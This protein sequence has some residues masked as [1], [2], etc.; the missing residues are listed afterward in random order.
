MEFAHLNATLRSAHSRRSTRGRGRHGSPRRRSLLV[1]DCIKLDRN[2][3]QRSPSTWPEPTTM[4]LAASGAYTWRR[5]IGSTSCPARRPE[6]RD[7]P[8]WRDPAGADRQ[9]RHLRCG[10][11]H[12]RTYYFLLE[13][14]HLD[15][16][17]EPGDQVTPSRRVPDF[18]GL[19]ADLHAHGI[20]VPL[21]PSTVVLSPFSRPCRSAQDLDGENHHHDADAAGG[22][23][24]RR[25]GGL[26][27]A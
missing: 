9:P 11:R 26:G 1:A 17:T 15:L 16:G 19:D 22:S 8:P 18:T 23:E 10:S 3:G 2:S 27:D 14:S 21:S 20:N 7:R 5:R 12:G 24:R 6:C 4:G 13:N 25:A